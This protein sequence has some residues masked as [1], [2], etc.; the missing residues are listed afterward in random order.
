MLEVVKVLHHQ[1]KSLPKDK[2]DEDVFF[3]LS[4]LD[5]STRRW[6]DLEYCVEGGGS[7]EDCMNSM[8]AFMVDCIE[9]SPELELY[10]CP[11]PYSQ[12]MR[13]KD[14]CIGSAWLWSDLDE[15]DTGEIPRPHFLWKTSEGRHQALWKLPAF[16][17]SMVVEP[18]NRRMTILCE[19]DISGWDITQV[20][21]VPGSLNNK[22][23]P[24]ERVDT[25]IDSIGKKAFDLPKT[26]FE[27]DRER[28]EAVGTPLPENFPGPRVALKELKRK[29]NP[30]LLRKLLQ[31][32]EPERG[33]RSEVL[34]KLIREMWEAG[35]RPETQF[36]IIKSSVW[37]KF[38]GRTNADKTLWEAVMK[39][40]VSGKSQVE[41][42]RDKQKKESK[43]LDNSREE[44]FEEDD[45]EDR[46]LEVISFES[47]MGSINL[48]PGWMIEHIWSKNSWGIV[49]G[50]PKSFKTM[51][52]MEM[53]VSVASG[54]P[55]LGRFQPHQTGSVLIVQNEN[56]PWIMQD[57]LQKIMRARGLV[58][59]VIMKPN[60][61][62]IRRWP[63]NLQIQM[64]N[65]QGVMLDSPEDQ[66][67]LEEI[68]KQHKP[69]LVIFDPFY[70]MFSGDINNAREL[71]PTLKWL[72]RIQKTHA[73]AV[74]LIHHK[75]KANKGVRG[76]QALL[77][78]T[79][80]HGWSES[81]WSVSSEQTGA[82][83]FDI[84][85]EREFRGAPNGL[86]LSLK[87]KMN[88]KEYS[89]NLDDDQ[90]GGNERM[91]ELIRGISEVLEGSKS[92]GLT[93][94]R[95]LVSGSRSQLKACLNYMVEEGVAICSKN[96][97]GQ[98]VWTLK[99]G[100]PYNKGNRSEEKEEK[101]NSDL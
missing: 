17:P 35:I 5:R 83:T 65:Q 10:W 48:R 50:E 80:L 29:C 38:A 99:D 94:I 18:I 75:K 73:C 74:Q 8:N 39:A 98:R 88:L 57:R 96:G 49:G 46:Q 43:R 81:G 68:I 52:A 3:F 45:E 91:T 6:E 22:Y 66:D 69:I 62:E 44:D 47:L 28:D 23:H 60:S 76:G 67:M 78:S 86:P 95:E 11:L 7:V 100:G 20:L 56:S 77:G 79:I 85:V 82:D 34:W 13:K 36:V 21:R 40:K 64:V 93:S 72:L 26:L 84:R 2:R 15:A 37:N 58:G 55:F 9:N 61:I 71:Q 27:G 97:D 32:E 54:V 41:I 101:E 70:L 51:L 63:R 12:P 90:D 33:N 59:K 16:L 92:L 4:T 14:Y 42:Q 53:A 89:L 25:I 1:Y 19:A 31:K 30:T 24:P 87:L